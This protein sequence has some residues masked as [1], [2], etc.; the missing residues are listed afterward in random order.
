LE[1]VGIRLHPHMKGNNSIIDLDD[2]ELLHRT[3]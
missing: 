2:K 3:R 1:K